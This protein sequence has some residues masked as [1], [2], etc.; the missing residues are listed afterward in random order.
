MNFRAYDSTT[1][2]WLEAVEQN[3]GIDAELTLR[4]CNEIIELA[5]N[6]KDSALLGFAYFYL[7]QTY[8]CLNDSSNFLSCTSKA[9]SYLAQVQEWELLSRS[10]N[11]MG[12]L[13]ANRGNY[14]L[15]IEYY[16]KAM[17]CCNYY[18]NSLG[19]RCAIDI[20]VGSMDIKAGR[21]EEA[22]EYFKR[23]KEQIK[24]NPLLPEYHPFSISILVN[25]SKCY[26]FQG[27][28]D[29][30]QK[31]FDFLQADH[32]KYAE[33]VDRI[34]MWC[35]E[36][37]YYHKQ[38]QVKER[39]LRIRLVGEHTTGNIPIMD[40]F[41]DY[42]DYLRMLLQ[43]DYDDE[44]WK[45]IDMIEPIVKIS[46]TVYLQQKIISL[47]V[48]YYRSRGKNA[49]YLKEA[50]LYFELSEYIENEAREMINVMLDLQRDLAFA[51]QKQQDMEL[52]NT[53]LQRKSMEDPL[54]HLWNRYKL[55]EISS[56]LFDEAIQKQEPLAV[57][58]MDI[59][60]FKELNDHY[61]HQYGDEA[62]IALGKVLNRIATERQGFCARYG[63][64]EFVL[65]YHGITKEQAISAMSAI[66]EAVEQLN[67]EHKYS[68]ALPVMTVSQ[69]MCYGTP[70]PGSCFADF[71]EAAD[72]NLYNIKG[73][74]RNHYA[75]GEISGNENHS[76][77]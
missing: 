55:D 72:Q 67:I 5:M 64:D 4:Y 46:Q 39:D 47:K 15:A 40:L 50:G 17:E 22:E 53:R 41:D 71:M 26:L 6:K 54:T 63:G 10:Y 24:Q 48:K 34:S 70:K 30:M 66:K 7:G 52:E 35:I 32:W 69:G 25:L 33:D 38:N 29:K 59:D 62:L 2:A 14:P 60:Y 45:I 77:T 23:A 31:L 68:K 28:Y 57:E 56:R 21:Y 43:T 16:R 49:E 58:I 12:I 73:K 76:D 44:F 42:Y 61:G 75:I 37:M 19:Q 36:A 11:C 20:N 51:E 8:Y 27:K 1:R 9:I 13:A 65:L 18:E 74:T 3:I